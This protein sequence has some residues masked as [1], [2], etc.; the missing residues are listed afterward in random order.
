MLCQFIRTM[1][2]RKHSFFRGRCSLSLIGCS[3]GE[4]FPWC[5]S[6]FLIK[7]LG[8]RLLDFWLLR[9]SWCWESR[10]TNRVVQGRRVNIAG[11][12]C[13]LVPVMHPLLLL[14]LLLLLHTGEAQRAASE[15]RSCSA[16]GCRHT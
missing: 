12:R 16:M 8:F 2:E 7:C 14:L 4:G 6:L 9:F 13:T 1:L 11:C 15:S 10:G 5:A 3:L